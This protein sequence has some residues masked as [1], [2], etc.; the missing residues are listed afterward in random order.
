MASIAPSFASVSIPAS[1]SFSSSSSSESSSL[2]EESSSSS[3]S[4]S[5]SSSSISSSS[6]SSSSS[7]FSSSFSSP[8]FP[9]PMFSTTLRISSI[10]RSVIF[11]DTPLKVRSV[12]SRNNADG[13]ARNAINKSLRTSIG[14]KS[15]SSSSSSSSVFFVDFFLVVF[16]FFGGWRSSSTHRGISSTIDVNCFGSD[17]CKTIKVLS[18]GI[19]DVATPLS[20][21][22]CFFSQSFKAFAR[23]LRASFARALFGITSVTEAS[24]SNFN[25]ASHASESASNFSSSS[26]SSSFASLPLSL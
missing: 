13:C 9:A 17:T 12:T 7:S 1:E 23:F 8:R 6:E 15:F 5:S 16:F 10:P 3:S 21:A 18:S 2:L 22:F 25:T 20:S 4:E 19:I 11:P 26:S 24:A 14:S